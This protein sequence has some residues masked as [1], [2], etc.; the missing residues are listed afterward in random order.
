[1]MGLLYIISLLAHYYLQFGKRFQQ[2]H[3][4][5]KGHR[6]TKTPPA[7]TT[8]PVGATIFIHTIGPL[9]PYKKKKGIGGDKEKG[10]NIYKSLPLFDGHLRCIV[11]LFFFFPSLLYAL[12]AKHLIHTKVLLFF[13]GGLRED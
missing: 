1:M 6:K 9:K 4:Q 8:G 11:F 2:L 13:G 5:S 3:G 12:P 10:K 7:P